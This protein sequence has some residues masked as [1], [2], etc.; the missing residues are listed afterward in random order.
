MVEYNL[1]KVEAEGSNP[2]FRFLEI[3]K[4]VSQRMSD[5]V[6]KG[7]SLENWRIFLIPGVRIPPYPYCSLPK[8]KKKD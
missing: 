2:F 1:A 7:T 3:E 4:C 5:R 8:I 6:V